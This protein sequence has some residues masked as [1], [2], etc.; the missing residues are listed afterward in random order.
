MIDDEYDDDGEEEDDYGVD[1]VGHARYNRR[2]VRLILVQWMLMLT[3]IDWLID[4]LIM[5]VMVMALIMVVVLMMD[6]AGDEEDWI[7]ESWCVLDVPRCSYIF[8]HD[9]SHLT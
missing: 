8:I 3:M 1:G 7:S 4:W 9:V 6:G 5:V 2:E